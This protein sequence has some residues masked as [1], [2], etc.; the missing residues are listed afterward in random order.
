MLV[1]TKTSKLESVKYSIKWSES[2]NVST[3]MYQH[4]QQ[5]RYSNYDNNNN[6]LS[7]TINQSDIHVTV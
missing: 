2:C 7:K 4:Q 5:Q 3:N 1:D 6:K